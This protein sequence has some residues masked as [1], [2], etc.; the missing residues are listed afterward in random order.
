M[1]RK[2]KHEVAHHAIPKSRGGTDDPHNIRMVDY[3]LHQHYHAIARNMLPK[4]LAKYLT[5]SWISR[6]YYMV[7]VKR[8]KKK[9]RK[10]N[11]TSEIK[12]GSCGSRCTIHH[13]KKE[14]VRKL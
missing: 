13:T 3:R 8:K 1:S 2:K 11:R 14:V 4:E 12:C 10:Y 9:P 7:A 5:D 6:D